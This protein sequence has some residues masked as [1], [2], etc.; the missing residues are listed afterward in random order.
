MKIEKIWWR[1]ITPNDLFNIEKP[2]PP[3]PKGQLHIDVPNVNALHDFFDYSHVGDADTW[4]PFEI[5]VKALQDPEV[6]SKITFRPRPKNNRYDIPQQNLNAEGSERHPAWTSAYG[7]PNIHGK[8]TSTDAA[9]EF[10]AEN[11][12]RIVIFYDANGNYYADFVIGEDLPANWPPA[13]NVIFTDVPS[14]SAA[15]D[16]ENP[17]LEVTDSMI[18]KP[19][20]EGSEAKVYKSRIRHPNQGNQDRVQPPIKQ[21]RGLTHLQKRAIEKRALDVSIEH[22]ET[23]GFLDIRDVGDQASYDITMIKDGL[24][25]FVEVKG[26]TGAGQAVILTRNEVEV[27]T[28][29]YPQN[30]LALVRGIKLE[31]SDPPIAS[32]GEL[33][34]FLPWKLN[35]ENLDP[36]VFEYKI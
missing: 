21:G 5:L 19:A 2:L 9:R 10:L 32:G 6:Q 22:F 17:E 3:G 28:T 12:I 26:T 27:H 24:I 30:A 16:F 7:W 35:M 8:L 33:V 36:V 4:P 29:Y 23:L 31:K 14:G 18:L 15:L 11:E 25:H 20:A 1:R 13:C 34:L